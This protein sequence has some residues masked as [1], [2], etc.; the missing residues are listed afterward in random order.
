[1]ISVVG[2]LAVIQY[3]EL[4]VRSGYTRSVVVLRSMWKVMKSSIC[5]VCWNPV[6]ST[7]RTSVDIDASAN[8]ELMDVLLF[9]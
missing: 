8:P 9:R 3:S 1:M 5:R 7:G 6:S 2:V 4:V